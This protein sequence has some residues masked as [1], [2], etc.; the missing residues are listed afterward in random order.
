MVKSISVQFLPE[1]DHEF[2]LGSWLITG[3]FHA[4]WN[5]WLVSVVHLRGE[6]DGAPAKFVFP[7]ATH[8]V[9]VWSLDPSQGTYDPDSEDK[10]KFLRPVDI[11]QQF[12]AESDAAALG[13]IEVMMKAVTDGMLSPDQDYR[14]AWAKLLAPGKPKAYG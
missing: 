5:Q 12:E 8:E 4:A 1:E 11:I 9:Q 13:R 2:C 14:S 6:K 3:P 7:E 10:P